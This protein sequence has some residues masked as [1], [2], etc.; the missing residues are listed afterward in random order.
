MNREVGLGNFKGFRVKD[1]AAPIEHAAVL[2]MLRIRNSFKEVKVPITPAAVLR[3]TGAL[4]CFDDGILGTGL[5]WNDGLQ[6]HIV[7]P[8]VSEVI[9]VTEPIFWSTKNLIQ[10]GLGFTDSD[11]AE[12]SIRGSVQDAPGLELVEVA[13]GPPHHHL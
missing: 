4:A 2:G 5:W 13:V 11:N 9:L 7:I 12:L 1:T 10:S 6:D 8:A 3:G